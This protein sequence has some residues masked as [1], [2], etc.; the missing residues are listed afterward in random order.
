MTSITDDRRPL[1]A[2][3]DNDFL[4]IDAMRRIVAERLPSAQVTWTGAD[5]RDAIEY[6]T[7]ARPAP[8]LLIADMSLQGLQ[9]PEV[10]RRIRLKSKKLAM[11]GMTSFPLERYTDA[12]HHAGAQGLVSKAQ[13]NQIGDAIELVASGGVMPGFDAP[14]AAYI[15]VRHEADNRIPLTPRE[16]EVA[17]LCAEGMLNDE[18]AERLGMTE[19]TVRKHL[20]HVMDKL[21]YKSARQI[22][23]M[24]GRYVD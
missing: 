22:A 16:Q 20:Q 11:L 9:G 23:A 12:M 17:D 19:G 15:R 6:C 3:L 10:C 4:T 21:G 5:G 13:L 24:Y 18:I 2:I 8:A 14:R 7:D 1:V